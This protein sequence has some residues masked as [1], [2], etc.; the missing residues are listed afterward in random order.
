MSSA[1]IV[2]KLD[3]IE[4]SLGL[5]TWTSCFMDNLHAPVRWKCESLCND[6]KK[7]HLVGWKQFFRL[8]V[9]WSS[10]SRIS[11]STLQPMSWETILAWFLHDPH[12]QSCNW[13]TC[14]FQQ[15]SWISCEVWIE[16]NQPFCLLLYA[17]VGTM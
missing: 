9:E 16:S 2:C 17:T 4:W 11:H 1:L 7:F 3:A 10:K 14:G 15:H 12:H 8:L 5:I 13:A 6:K